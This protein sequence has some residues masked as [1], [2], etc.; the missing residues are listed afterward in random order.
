MAETTAHPQNHANARG[1]GWALFIT[2]I[3]VSVVLIVL[4]WQENLQ[5]D[6]T[7]TPGYYRDTFVVDDSVYATVTAEAAAL[8]RSLTP[9]PQSK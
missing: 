5:G 9:V 6:N 8:E 2:F 4:T 3:A 7:T 1:I